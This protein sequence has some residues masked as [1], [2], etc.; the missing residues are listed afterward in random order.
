MR[1]VQQQLEMLLHAAATGDVAGVQKFFRRSGGAQNSVP[2]SR[3]APSLLLAVQNGHVDV[4]RIL[5]SHCPGLANMALANGQCSLLYTAVSKGF[6]AVAQLLLNHGA[7]IDQGIASSGATPLF[8]ACQHGQTA[9]VEVLL[10]AKADATLSDGTGATPLYVACQNGHLAA[11]ELLLRLRPTSDA[12]ALDAAKATGATPLYVAAQKGHT[13][14][15]RQLLAA[16]AAVN[17]CTKAGASPLLVGALQGHA[18]VV[19]LL[20]RRSADPDLATADGT[21]PLIAVCADQEP[22]PPSIPRALLDAGATIALPDGSLTRSGIAL[23]AAAHRWNDDDLLVKADERLP[24]D[25]A[26]SSSVANSSAAS[27]VGPGSPLAGRLASLSGWGAKPDESRALQ[28]PSPLLQTRVQLRQGQPSLAAGEAAGATAE[29][30]AAAPADVAAAASESMDRVAPSVASNSAEEK[31]H[32]T[33]HAAATATSMPTPSARREL[34][35]VDHGDAPAGAASIDGVPA[36]R[37]DKSGA[38]TAS[39]PA[40]VVA[41]EEEEEEDAAEEDGEEEEAV[42]LAPEEEEEEEEEEDGVE[43]EG[44]EAEAAGALG[45]KPSA[46][47]KGTPRSSEEGS[48]DDTADPEAREAANASLRAAIDANDLDELRAAIER[49]MRCASR[50]ALVEARQAR[51]KL[52]EKVRKAAQQRRR[53]REQARAELQT[54]HVRAR[55][56]RTTFCARR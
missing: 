33:V 51:D 28:P 5:L 9:A 22:P 56:R 23:I 34:F 38:E 24:T 1:P 53:A 2:P 45:G 41:A 40:A 16:G 43:G 17:Q 52:R 30:V 25:A 13:A 37:G 12:T 10:S 27:S 18:S 42:A 7:R 15:V 55:A 11:V 3:C 54:A 39:K 4:C 8:I 19:D 47:A 49:H 48:E 14:I 35:A 6:S 44:E 21:T 26:A 20:I 31:A 36:A 50:S 32:A 46:D 29:A